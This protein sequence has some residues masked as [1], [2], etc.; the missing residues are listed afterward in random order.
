MAHGYQVALQGVTL[1][2]RGVNVRLTLGDRHVLIVRDP[3]VASTLIGRPAIDR[4]RD[5]HVPVTGYLHKGVGGGPDHNGHGRRRPKRGPKGPPLSRV[6][7][8]CPG[9]SP[10]TKDRG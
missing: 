8:S 9:K 1:K 7:R 4:Y 10:G 2:I 5:H 6:Q 3:I